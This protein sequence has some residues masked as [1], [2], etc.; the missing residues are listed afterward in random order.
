MK[1]TL[2]A[3]E[4]RN[5]G[6]AGVWLPKMKVAKSGQSTRVGNQQRQTW[7]TA[8]ERRKQSE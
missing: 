5:A 2:G 7:F 1:A 6:S 3:V 4:R 8:G